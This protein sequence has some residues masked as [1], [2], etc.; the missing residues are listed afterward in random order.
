MFDCLSVCTSAARQDMAVA[1]GR[2][3]MSDFDAGLNLLH[4]SQSDALGAPKVC[5]SS[6][7]TTG[8]RRVMG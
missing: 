5:H 2:L 8:L 7:M 3:Q 6:L 4:E 1:D